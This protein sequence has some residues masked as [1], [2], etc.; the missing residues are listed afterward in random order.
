MLAVLS[1]SQSVVRLQLE[2]IP[3]HW[4]R[5]VSGHLVN[6]YSCAIFTPLFFWAGRRF[7]IDAGHWVHR[8]PLHLALCAICSALKFVVDWGTMTQ[9]LGFQQP[10]LSKLLTYGF[11]S[12]NIAFWCMAAAIHAIEFQRRAREREVLSAR[13]QARLSEAQ[14]SALTARLHPH[15]LF[16]TLQGISTLVHR[17]P[18]AADTMLGHL[19]TL[20]RKTLQG[21]PRHEVTLGEELALLEDYLAI[22]QTRFGD[23]V[24]ITRAVPSETLSAL[25]PYMSLQPL[26]E[27]A[28][29]H[30]IAR[31]AAAGR[32]SIGARRVGE[33]LELTVRDDGYG[34]AA[35]S[36]REGVGLGTTRGRLVELYGRRAS[37]TLAGDPDGGTV[38]TMVLPFHETRTPALAEVAV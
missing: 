10:P 20:L 24:T 14:L 33:D 16:N 37:L 35:G 15:F 9:V 8:L 36:V 30:G 6:W 11:I 5:L 12:E 34:P 25:V 17:D 7:P 22:V 32:V 31:R 13:L 2:S 23:R 27:N 18:Q 1:I 26:L 19:S 21:D 3:I 38:A 4:D 28:F 29:E